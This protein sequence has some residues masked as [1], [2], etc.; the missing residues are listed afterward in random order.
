MPSFLGLNLISVSN[1]PSIPTL[2][3]EKLRILRFL[4]AFVTSARGNILRNIDFWI[5][6]TSLPVSVQAMIR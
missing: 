1:V 3:P 2:V 5:I 6:V 4:V